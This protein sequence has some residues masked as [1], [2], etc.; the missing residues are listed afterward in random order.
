MKY[1]VTLL[2]VICCL[3][4]VYA[5]TSHTTNT[6]LSGDTATVVATSMNNVSLAETNFIKVLN[7]ESVV[8]MD[9][10]SISLAA[11]DSLSMFQISPEDSM[12]KAATESNTQYYLMKVNPASDKD[13]MYGCLLEGFMNY[14]KSI[15]T[16][17]DAEIEAA[18]DNIRKMR[19]EFEEAGIYYNQLGQNDKAYKF[20]ECYLNIPRL[21]F[22]EGENF[23]RNLN[24]P[25]YVYFVA[26]QAHNT[27]KFEDAVTFFQEYINLGEKRN[28]ETC[29]LFWAKDLDLLERHNEMVDVLDEG[30]MN[31]PRNIDMLKL[32]VN[33]YMKKHNKDKAQEM[34]DRA[35]VL[36]PNDSGLRFLKAMLEDENGRFEEALPIYQNFYAS[37]STNTDIRR[38]LALCYY[39]LAAQQINER[40]KA[41][42]GKLIKELTQKATN[43]YNHAIPML[44]RIVDAQPNGK[45][46]LKLLYALEDAYKQTGQMNE[47]K[48]VEAMINIGGTGETLIP[49]FNKWYY[50]QLEVALAEW[51]A[52][53][54]FETADDYK[55]R[56]NKKN[57]EKLIAQTRSECETRFINEYGGFFDLGGL[58]LKPYDP[59]HETFRIQTSKGNIHVKVPNTNNEAQEF[60]KYGNQIRI[61]N[62]QLRVDNEGTLLLAMADIVTPGGKS[63]KFDATAPLIYGKEK[64]SVSFPPLIN[65]EGSDEKSLPSDPSVDKNIPKTKNHNNN[66][67]ALIFA[68]EDYTNVEGVPYAKNDGRMF[69][70][71]CMDV[72]GVDEKHIIHKEDATRNEMIDAVDLIKR[73]NSTYK[74]VR[75]LVYYSG[76]G[77]PNPSTDEAYLMPSDASP[78]NIDRTGYK[79]STFY[80]ELAADNP[81]SVTVFLDACFSGAKKDGEVMDKT[82]RGVVIKIKEETPVN[83]MV[84]FSACSGTQT[85]YPYEGQKHG[86]FTYYLLRKL[87]EEK[88]KV[89]YKELAEYL[90]ENVKKKNLE[91]GKQEQ[92]PTTK[93]QLPNNVWG[94]WRLDK[95]D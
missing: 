43:N 46:D 54:E 28:Q 26:S 52:R 44:N 1:F 84:I 72:L 49:D 36:S 6:S 13:A 86:M 21:P 83:N 16:R 5:L 70:R 7:D 58:T 4:N 63:Y 65:S 41:Q 15:N 42:E 67:Y 27:R 74:N 76:H 90:L 73:I 17:E 30:L 33:L 93:S 39:N 75:L 60:K 14:I 45:K 64:V 79:L 10:D 48:R 19:P 34:L 20:L 55:S 56:V 80:K 51:E 25:N 69:K 95:E 9:G 89:T 82:A 92:T 8:V 2:S 12:F 32:S 3:V 59:D 37:D 18:K 85:A 94:D 24:Y 31:Y 23:M 50:P 81:K 71:Y 11:G 29:Y 40:N 87:Q 62:P 61:E 57:R 47:A 78:N 88:G 22:F 91:L 38:R 66:T 77:V 53:G 35:L 68:N